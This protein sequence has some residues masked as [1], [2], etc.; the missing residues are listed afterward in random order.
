M[1]IMCK[2]MGHEIPY[3]IRKWMEQVGNDNYTHF[4]CE[5]CHE[6]LWTFNFRENLK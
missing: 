5:R 4:N 1:K 6:Y 2:L 3:E